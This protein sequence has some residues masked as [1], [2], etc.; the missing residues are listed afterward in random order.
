MIRFG[1]SMPEHRT[2]GRSSLLLRVLAAASLGC[3]ILAGTVRADIRPPRPAPNVTT[4]NDNHSLEIRVSDDGRGAR[5]LIPQ[6]L[7]ESLART[8]PAHADAG[9]FPLRTVVAGV[10]MSAAL[11]I[12]GLLLARGRGK[13]RARSLLIIIGGTSVAA[14]VGSANLAPYPGTTPAPPPFLGEIIHIEPADRQSTLIPVTVE[15]TRSGPIQLMLQ[16]DQVPPIANLRPTVSIFQNGVGTSLRFSQKSLI[17]STTSPA[18]NTPAD[19][20]PTTQ[21]STAG[22]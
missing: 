13:K 18:Q 21:P 16:V 19:P 10:A 12:G 14:A 17:P 6:T 20:T 9:F 8:E 3:L 15:T 7:L 22:K 2:R 11:V 5:L 1:N 4:D